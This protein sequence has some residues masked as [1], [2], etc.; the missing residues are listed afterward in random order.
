M[1][2]LA[3]GIYD[4]AF[5]GMSYVD[6]A[7]EEF[8]RFAASHRGPDAAVSGKEGRAALQKVLERLDVALERAASDRTRDAGKQTRAALASLANATAADL[9]KQMAQA[10]QSLTKL[11]KKFSADGLEARDDAEE[12]AARSTH[13]L[14]IAIAVAV[15][16]A[17]GVGWLVGRDL[18]NPLEKLVKVID[19]LAAGQLD[20]TVSPKLLR[21]RDEIGKLAG[22]TAMFRD[23][24][25]QNARAGD[26]RIRMEQRAEREKIQALRTAADMMERETTAV[27][28]KSSESGTL[29][30]IRA[31]ELSASAARVLASVAAAREASVTALHHS[32]AVASAGEELS[33]SA[34]EI[35]G[36]IGNTTAEI[37]SA[38]RA[39][40]QA[41][42]IIDELAAAVGQIGSVARLIGDIASRTNLLALN[43]TIE[44]SRAGEAGRG[45]AVV[46]NEVKSLANQTARSTE[47]IARNASAVQ[48]ATHDVVMVVSEMVERVMSIEQIT[49]AVA[50]AAMQQTEATGNIARN[51]LGCAEDMR[52]VSAQIGSVTEEAHGTGAAI[53]DMQGLAETVS[54]QISELRSVMVRI[55]RNSSEAADR[56]ADPRI[57][58]D[59]PATL[60]VDGSEFP[61]RC[62]NLSRGGAR[63]TVGQDMTTGARV[64]LRLPGLPDLP[65]HLVTGG[66]PAGVKFDWAADDAP[67]ELHDWLHRR[68]AA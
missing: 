12:L 47:E 13:L 61:V 33:F 8:L 46:A 7:Q 3:I 17:L 63:V 19:G 58:I 49:Q 22:A 62:A 66:D 50:Q 28:R 26:E 56:R 14:L 54:D 5:M 24:M 18:S 30:A 52:I 64:L 27:S 68:A 2:R 51:I 37:A 31:D 23:A 42:T 29:L 41:R 53:S 1:G 44:A 55:V 65:G 45:F 15:C 25:E 9:P 40:E 11:V 32:Q 38:A 16:L 6:Q 21:R 57:Q 43:A 4:H 36:Q 35:A 20:R 48:Q 34:R 67:A 10:D 60:I 39:G 59:L